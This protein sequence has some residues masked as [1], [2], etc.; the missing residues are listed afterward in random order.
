MNR[1]WDVLLELLTDYGATP[2][3]VRLLSP[4]PPTSHLSVHI[5]CDSNHRK[6]VAIPKLQYLFL[7][8]SLFPNPTP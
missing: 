5:N 2:G 3:I 4:D 7:R 6:L 1:K 8:I